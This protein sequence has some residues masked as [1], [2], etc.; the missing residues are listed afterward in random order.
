MAL[1]S[2][3]MAGPGVPALPSIDADYVGYAVTDLPDHFA[4]GPVAATNNTPLDNPIT[5]AGATL[6]R[7]LFYD[8]RLSHDNGTACA[9]C[10]QQATAFDDPNQ[11]SEGFE[12]GLTGRHSTPLS[13]TAYYANGRAFWD[14]RAASLE[15]QALMPIQ[16]PVE[17]GTDLNQLRGELA[18]TDFYPK[19][20]LDAFG[21]TEVTDEKIGKAIAQF[22]RSMVSYQSKYDQAVEAGTS[23][24]PDFESVFTA[25]ELRG[26]EIFHGESKCS[27]CHTTHAQVGDR[28]RNIGLDADNSADEGA[29]DGKFK[30]M[31]LRNVAVRERF[32]HDGRF[33]TLEE[34]I[35]F[36]NSGVQANPNLDNKLTKN[37]EP[38]RL[39]LSES[40]KAALVAFLGTLT[41]NT[42]L[43]SELFANPFV[44]LAG[45]YD[46]DGLVN[47][48][49]Y[50]LWATLYGQGDD[51]RADG[52]ED[53]IVNAADFTV[54]RDNLGASW[55]DFAS[56]FATA[57]PEPATAL[58]VVFGALLAA[59]P[60][61]RR[62]GR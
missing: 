20:F 47:T 41:D 21:S 1:S 44:A 30:T 15:E 4:T 62:H 40:D 2:P 23:A 58:T 22:V 52:N 28:A 27:Q 16:D 48:D 12:G 57:V 37:G 36:Y 7:V 14:E 59:S 9:S 5:N 61:R 34:V 51:L 53:G 11:F 31:S 26:M 38:L 32:M 55:E 18:A 49:D 56:A 50:D 10:H 39:N 3:A 35:E 6:G 60:R 29:G 24:E 46:G 33:S 8:A 13:N 19:L 54:W 17:M 25:Q 45:D 42:F 43:T